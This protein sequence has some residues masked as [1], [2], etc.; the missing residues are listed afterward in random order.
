MSVLPSYTSSVYLRIFSLFTAELEFCLLDV[1][2]RE[3]PCKTL[4]DD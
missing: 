2:G 1:G 4:K 3:R